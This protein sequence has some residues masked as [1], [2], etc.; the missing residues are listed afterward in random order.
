MAAEK[1]SISIFHSCSVKR[2]IVC[3]C[4]GRCSRER[5]EG[6]GRESIVSEEFEWIVVR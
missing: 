5:L 3:V 6:V 1:V 4:L 2:S